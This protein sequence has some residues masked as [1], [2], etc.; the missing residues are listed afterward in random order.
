MLRNHER[1]LPKALRRARWAADLN[2]IQVSEA[3]GCGVV[4]ASRAER[5]ESVPDDVLARLCRFYGIDPADPTKHQPTAAALAGVLSELTS[6]DGPAV[7][8]LPDC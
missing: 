7:L 3:V 1:P 4:E 8:D 2:L 5:G 6:Y